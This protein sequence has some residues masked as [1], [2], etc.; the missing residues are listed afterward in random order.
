[1]RFTCGVLSELMYSRDISSMRGTCIENM[2][3]QPLELSL[4][5]FR[6]EESRIYQREGGGA[7]ILA[8]AISQQ[9]FRPAVLVKLNKASPAAAAASERG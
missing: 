2:Y 3:F 5:N 6:V 9:F 1:M 7:A 4:R 8:V